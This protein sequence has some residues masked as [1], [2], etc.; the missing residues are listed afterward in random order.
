M[1][2]RHAVTR[3]S[4][5]TRSATVLCKNSRGPGIDSL[6]EALAARS[7]TRPM[8]RSEHCRPTS[9]VD[10]KLMAFVAC[11]GT[12][13]GPGYA[14]TSLAG[15][16]S[17]EECDH[18]AAPPS[19][20]LR[21]KETPFHRPRAGAGRPEHLQMAAHRITCTVAN[22]WQPQSHGQC[23]ANTKQTMASTNAWQTHCKTMANAMANAWQTHSKTIVNAMTNA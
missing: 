18:G 6:D 20:A 4:L 21:A 10:A 12:A 7:A 14:P 17:T 3:A 11:T 19:P 22:A 5:A 15:S 23:I 2:Q 13:D 1:A 9:R 16:A 8:Q